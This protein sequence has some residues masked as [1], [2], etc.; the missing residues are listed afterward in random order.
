MQGVPWKLLERSDRGVSAKMFGI[1]MTVR[2]SVGGIK[3]KCEGKGKRECSCVGKPGS[4]NFSRCLYFFR[5][6]MVFVR[7]STDFRV[8]APCAVLGVQKR[9]SPVCRSE[10]TFNIEDHLCG[11]SV[12][13]FCLREQGFA[14]FADLFSNS[15]AKQQQLAH[16]NLTFSRHQTKNEKRRNTS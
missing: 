6:P 7:F 1:N 3:G 2:E 16:T 14:P 12:P 4:L 11:I 8:S 5:F 13:T 10:H 15:F 9:N